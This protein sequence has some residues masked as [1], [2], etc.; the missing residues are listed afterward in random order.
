L[1]VLEAAGPLPVWAGHDFGDAAD[2]AGRRVHLWSSAGPSGRGWRGSGFERS[3]ADLG[4]FREAGASVGAGQVVR[5]TGA[6]AS[7]G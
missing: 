1:N 2:A 7:C 3:K 5:V 4:E 6:A